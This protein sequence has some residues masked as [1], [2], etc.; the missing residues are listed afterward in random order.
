[1]KKLILTLI[2]SMLGLFSSFSFAAAPVFNVGSA[3]VGG[4]ENLWVDRKSSLKDNIREIFFP[5]MWKWWK[6]FKTIQPIFTGLL[7]VFIVRA[8]AMFVMNANNEWELKKAKMNLLYIVFWTFLLFG[9]IW[10]LGSVL[11][12]WQTNT[13]ASDVAVATQNTLIWWVLIFLKS[14]AYYLAIILVVYY[15][16]KIMQWNEKE[17]KIKAWRSW[18]INVILALISIKVLD[19]VYLIAQKQ[20]FWAQASSLIASVWTALG[21]VLWVI[22]VFSLVYAWFLLVTSRWN[23]ESFKKAKTIVRNIFLVIFIVFLFIVIV[24]DLVKNFT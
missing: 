17:D 5:D 21:W 14:F 9:S 24:F 4:Y 19:Y 8:W 2:F 12:V 10:I 20:N 15:W 11:N 7:L 1:M 23:E 13:T 22:V 3:W 18:V 6:I 16:F